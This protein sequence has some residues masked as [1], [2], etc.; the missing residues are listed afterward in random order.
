MAIW[1]KTSTEWVVMI[2]MSTSVSFDLFQLKGVYTKSEKVLIKQIIR[3]SCTVLA[4]R[5]YSIWF[6]DNLF[7]SYFLLYLRD[8]NVYGRFHTTDY[9]L[10]T[11][12]RTEVKAPS[13][14]EAQRGDYQTKSMRD[15]LRDR[16]ANEYDR[17]LQYAKLRSGINNTG[18]YMVCGSTHTASICT[19]QNV[20][21][22]A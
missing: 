8:L 11:V 10:S 13:F 4:F 12:V 19:T 6:S 14:D 7:Y 21:F 9:G 22:Y 15:G 16:L 2:D 1:D 5:S 18:T 17:T 3:K 20:H